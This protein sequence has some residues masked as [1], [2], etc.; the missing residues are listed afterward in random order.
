[1]LS[2]ELPVFYALAEPVLAA[3]KF[4]FFDHA[5]RGKSLQLFC[6]AEVPTELTKRAGAVARRYASIAAR[7]EVWG[8]YPLAGL[9]GQVRTLA[10]LGLVPAAEREGIDAGL[11]AVVARLDNAITR[12]ITHQADGAPMGFRLREQPFPGVAPMFA[13]ETPAGVEAFVTLD[14]PG[15]LRAT[16]AAAR[17]LFEESFARAA[18]SACP[19]SEQ[20]GRWRPYRD[21]L[22]RSI[23]EMSRG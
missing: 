11:R 5:R 12:G 17:S 7:D 22:L 19:L 1:M 13:L 4:Y 9:L 6:A 2:S 18:S 23:E 10:G 16:N 3:L 15:H 21:A 8:P 14:H 20:V